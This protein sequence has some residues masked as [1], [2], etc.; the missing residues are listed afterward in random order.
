MGRLHIR[1]ITVQAFRAFQERQSTPQLPMSGLVGVRGYNRD[2]KGS[3][4]AGKSSVAL[5]V[6]H[7][8]GFLPF[9]ASDQQNWHIKTPMQVELEL[10]SP[11][12]P[13]V[14]RRGKEFSLTVGGQTVKGSAKAVEEALTKLVGVPT[15]L[16]KALTYR[17]Q[18]ERGRFLTMK[19]AEK[20]EFLGIL[21]GTGELEDQIAEAIKRGN[22]LLAEVASEDAVVAALGS[23]LVEPNLPVLGDTPAL[24]ARL[25]AAQE[26]VD[27]LTARK[28]TA[29]ASIQAL[30]NPLGAELKELDTIPFVAPESKLAALEA[31]KAECNKRI[32][33]ASETEREEKRRLYNHALSYNPII[34]ELKENIAKE[35]A[36]KQLVLSSK[37]E[38]GSLHQS[39]CGTCKRPWDAVEGRIMEVEQVIGASIRE[40][41]IIENHK[42][43]LAR[44]EATRDDLLEQWR[45]YQQPMLTKLVEV[46]SAIE[47]QIAAERAAAENAKTLFWQNIQLQ[48]HAVRHKYE[49]EMLPHREAIVEIDGLLSKLQVEILSVKQLI[50]DAERAHEYYV[51]QVAKHAESKQALEARRA[52]NDAKRVKANEELDYADGLR[53]YLGSL[54]DEVLIQISAEA[55]SL[56]KGIPNTPTTTVT[57]TSETVTGK[58]TTKSEIKPV[59]TKNGVAVDIKSGISGGQ[60]ESVELAVDLSITKVIGQRT[61]VRPGFMIFDESFSAH[62]LPVKE[63]CLQVLQKAAED[64]LILVIDHATELRDYF[65]CFIDVESKNDV[66]SFMNV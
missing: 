17:Q 45:V 32:N 52:A 30:E 41:E 7:A 44:I 63:A 62:C 16:H 43:Q 57:F 54:F 42:K 36:L 31:Q 27:K 49:A 34:N 20:K 51:A 59:I 10:D 65:S 23:Q 12:G 15:D 18:Q 33:A 3:S 56:L 21:L 19:D 35:G 50:K 28:L 48:K 2:S 26:A 25:K 61:G 6:A 4:G 46:R 64:C 66:S 47:Q 55:N 24:H 9:A 8:F 1:R 40:L 11:Q 53:K 14:L 22:K 60:L 29:S 37:Q 13:A 38:M 5:A 58:G 39:K